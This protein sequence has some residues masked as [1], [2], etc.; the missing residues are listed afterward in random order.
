MTGL[1][2]ELCEDAKKYFQE[3]KLEGRKRFK[4]GKKM[5]VGLHNHS[6]SQSSP[7]G[8]ACVVVH[9]CSIKNCSDGGH[10]VDEWAG[11]VCVPDQR[12]LGQEYFR[13]QAHGR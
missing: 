8:G 2:V 7:V 4:Y 10:M 3:Q 1:G 6:R 13:W 11:G 9:A 12:R 5:W